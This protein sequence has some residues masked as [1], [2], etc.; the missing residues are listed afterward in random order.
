VN[1]EHQHDRDDDDHQLHVADLHRVVGVGRSLHR[2]E[3]DAARNQRLQRPRARALQELHVVLQED[4]HADRGDQ[5]REAARAAQRAVGDALERPA[6][7]GVDDHRE[8]QHRDDR[9]R[10][11]ADADGIHDEERDQRHE[12]ADHEDLAVR[13]IDHAHDA[14]DHRVADRDQPVDGAEGQ[15]VDE[16]L[17]EV[18]HAGRSAPSLLYS[19]CRRDSADVIVWRQ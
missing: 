5:R 12:R 15:P 16:L 17:D 6:I 18:L 8:Q 19:R 11:P 10:H 7:G 13:E 3:L 2:P 1:A 4:R 9:D 14:V